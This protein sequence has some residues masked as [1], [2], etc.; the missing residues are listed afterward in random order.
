MNALAEELFYRAALLLAMT[1]VL[2][3]ATSWA[4]PGSLG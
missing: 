4:V 1:S 2:L 3:G